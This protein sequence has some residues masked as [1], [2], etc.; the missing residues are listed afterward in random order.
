MLARFQTLAD[1]VFRTAVPRPRLPGPAPARRRSPRSAS[2][3]S[4]ARSRS[5]TG[6]SRSGSSSP[7]TR[8]S[9][10]RTARCS[11]LLSLWDELQHARVLLGRLDD[12]LE[13]EPEQGSDELALRAGDDARGARRAARRRLPL[14]RAG[15]AADPRRRSTFTVEPGETVA[16]VGRSGSGKTTLIKLLAGLLE[17]TEGDD[18]LRRLRAADARLPHAAPADRLRAAGELPLRRHDRR[19]HRLRRGGASIPSA[20]RGRRRPRTPT[21]SSQRLPLGYDTRVGESGLRLSGGQ[22]Q[23]IAIARALYHRPPDPALRR[24]DE[25][26][27]HR[28]GARRSR[29]AST[30][31]LAGRTSFVIAHRLSTI[32]DADRIVVLERGPP[33]RAGHARRADGPAGAL[34][35]PREPAARALMFGRW[36]AAAPSCFIS[37]ETRDGMRRTP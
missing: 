33:R 24:G 2:S 18:P 30:T 1:R 17:P 13:Q 14:R 27:R 32:R 10:S 20:S 23:R 21:S 35:L 26:A 8:W 22:Q 34:L 12:V 5:S 7:S 28:V 9:R 15:G 6:S 29:R 3:C 11:S 37:R 25:R 31:S 19:Q 16:I 36:T 4:S